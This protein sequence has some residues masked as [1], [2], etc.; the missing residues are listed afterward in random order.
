M[1]ENSFLTEELLQKIKGIQIK[2]RHLVN[3]SFSGEYVSA[4]KGRG[5]EFEEV[6]EY[7]PGDDI[8]AIDWNVTAR[9]NKPFIKT[10]KD[11]RELTIMFVVDVSASAH[12]GT[13]SKFKNEIAAEI[14]ALLSWTALKNNDKVGLII[15]SD[16]VEHYLPPKKGRGHIWRLIR[17]ILTFKS[18]ARKTNMNIPLDF[19]NRVQKK[20]TITFL[21]SDFQGDNFDQ[22]LLATSRRHEMIAINVTD[23]REIDL[24]NIG[25]IELEDAETGDFRIIN[26]GSKTLRDSYKKASMKRLKNIKQFFERNG[27]DYIDI[28]TDQFYLDEIVKFFRYREKKR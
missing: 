11:E 22:Q 4:F 6:R 21:I 27:I 1:N 8:R 20:K 19:L 3:D 28:R 2:A 16:H 23:Q 15:F 12:F 5:I 24:P 13:I 9:Q 10:Y 25:Y 17:D 7:I 18:S 14:T 26:T